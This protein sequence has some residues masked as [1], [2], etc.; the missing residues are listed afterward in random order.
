MKSTANQ[1]KAA[2]ATG[3]RSRRWVA[4]IAALFLLVV[5]LATA[6]GQARPSTVRPSIHAVHGPGFSR[7]SSELSAFA[8]QTGSSKQRVEVIV[9]FREIPTRAHFRRMANLG[10][11]HRQALKLVR[12]GVF[13]LPL[14]AVRALANDPDVLYVSPNRSLNLT[15]AD[16]YEATIGGDAAQRYGWDGTGFSVAVIDSGISDHPDLHDPATGASRVVYSQSFV[17]GLDANDQYGHGTHV[18]GI[19][20]GNGQAS[21]GNGKNGNSATSIFGVAPNVNLVNLRVLDANGAGTDAQVIAA[22]EQ[23][24]ALKD[25]YNIRVINLSLGR[26]VFESY[27]QDPLCRAVEAAWRAGIVVVVAAGMTRW[28]GVSMPLLSLK[29]PVAVYLTTTVWSGNDPPLVTLRNVGVW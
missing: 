5:S 2:C 3:L 16:Q 1:T 27:T 22:I 25:T 20:A 8:T 23:A 29:T 9:Q 15:A 21:G 19:I 4:P 26:P 17:P 13:T 6:T 12:G 11:V 28:A 18:A 24:M 14:S 10:G 7:V